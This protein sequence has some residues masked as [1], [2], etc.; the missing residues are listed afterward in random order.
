MMAG[1]TVV[2]MYFDFSIE[3]PVACSVCQQRCWLNLGMCKSNI[4]H[5][6]Q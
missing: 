6:T 3:L 4:V 2:F 1:Y 5:G